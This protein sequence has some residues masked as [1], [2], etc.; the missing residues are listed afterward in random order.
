M[1]SPAPRQDRSQPVEA[2][3]WLQA[4]FEESPLDGAEA[5]GVFRARSAEIDVVLLDLTMPRMNGLETL[6]QLRRIAPAVPV[7]LT[8]GYGEGPFGDEPERGE[9]P[10]AVLPKP[11]AAEHL[12]A[13]IRRVMRK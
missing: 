7:V 5:V 1:S 6:R 10:D 8:S 9:G 4:L 3:A 2:Y 13:T 11:Y 12:L